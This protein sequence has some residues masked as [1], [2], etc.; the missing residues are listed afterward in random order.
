MIYD[1]SIQIQKINELT[2]EW[3][4]VFHLHAS[5]NKPR[6]D[7]EYLKAGAIQGK[8]YMVFEVRYFRQLEDISY[9]IQLYRI[10]FQ[11]VLFD[12]IDFD[13]FMLQHKV[14]KLLGGSV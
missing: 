2:E 4:E 8:R 13:D 14:V 10:L 11:G 5:I 7:N 12:I 6:K 1:K 3:E 9:N